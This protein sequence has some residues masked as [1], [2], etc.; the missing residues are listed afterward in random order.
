MNE[1]YIIL[2]IIPKSLITILI[3]NG[4]TVF[5]AYYIVWI[6]L[7]VKIW[8]NRIS[9]VD[10]VNEKQINRELKSSISTIIAFTIFNCIV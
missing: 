5:L 6:K 4:L 1:L 3:I 2:T 8:K 9:I 7:R 10:R